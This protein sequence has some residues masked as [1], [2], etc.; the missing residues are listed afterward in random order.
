M[1]AILLV[2]CG[3]N[4]KKFNRFLRLIEENFPFT[5]KRHFHSETDV[6]ATS[7]VNPRNSSYPLV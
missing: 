7:L 6:F 1:E 5:T 2:L 3:M 4:Q